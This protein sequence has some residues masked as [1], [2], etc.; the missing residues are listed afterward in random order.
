MKQ[1]KDKRGK[2]PKQEQEQSLIILR[3]SFHIF[4][5][6]MLVSHCTKTCFSHNSRGG[7]CG[8]TQASSEQ[9]ALEWVTVWLYWHTLANATSGM[10]IG[11]V[12][13][14]RSVR[15]PQHT[16]VTGP[17]CALQWFA[18]A[19]LGKWAHVWEQQYIMPCRCSSSFRVTAGIPIRCSITQ[20]GCAGVAL[21]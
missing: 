17:F 4:I 9:A 21:I 13:A 2:Y 19:V 1:K 18:C 15:E 7:Q 10:H 16:L 5:L 3:Y 20:K 11:S 6:V 8:S 14:I 12:N